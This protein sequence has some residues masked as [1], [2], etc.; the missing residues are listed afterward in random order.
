MLSVQRF[1][2]K[3]Q[4]YLKEYQR[5]RSATDHNF[6]LCSNKYAE[7][8]RELSRPTTRPSTSNANLERT[9]TLLILTRVQPSVPLNN[10][11]NNNNN[12][13]TSNIVSEKVYS[14]KHSYFNC[15]SFTFL[16]PMRLDDC[17]E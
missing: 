11:N 6:L 16:C 5:L 2:Q 7:K 14:L 4:N 12:L 17:G 9:R 10:N 1:R 13:S 15:Y 8:L 3:R